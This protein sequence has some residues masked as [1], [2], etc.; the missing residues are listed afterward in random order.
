M[1][2]SYRKIR[3]SKTNKVRLELI[4]SIISEYQR[5]GYV[6][7]L[8]QLYYQLVSRDVIPNRQKE[9]AKLSLPRMDG[10]TAS[11]G[12]SRSSSAFLI[13]SPIKN[14]SIRLQNFRLLGGGSL[15]PRVI[16]FIPNKIT[17]K[18]KLIL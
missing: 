10:Q 2:I 18:A 11:S 3:L 12:H 14:S 9:Y 1:K 6:L 5:E 8:R 4:N 16:N 15:L 17:S 13:Y 7:T